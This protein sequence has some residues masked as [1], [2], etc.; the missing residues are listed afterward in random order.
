MNA[1]KTKRR[2]VKR[3]YQSELR[4][5]QSAETRERILDCVALMLTEGAELSLPL[6]A[7]RA[8]V[9]APTVY[10]YFAT[11]EA[12]I[13]AFWD[14]ANPVF[15][16]PLQGG[17]P[18]ELLE[19]LPRVYANF[20]RHEPLMRALIN[21]PSGRMVRQ[22]RLPQRTR[23]IEKCLGDLT[24]A[25]PPDEQRLVHAVIKLLVSSP[26]WQELRDSYDLTGDEAGRAATWALRL[27]LA[28]LKRKPR[29]L[30][31]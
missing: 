12:L 11:R 16:V 2:S 15:N 30:E 10:R 19:I 23:A 9:S 6:V 18:D 1:G 7:R 13:E 17:T 21:T 22:Q 27:L 25:L 4:A 3:K 29:K 31:G 8:R 14:R 5:E 20:D 24:T 28:E 26:A